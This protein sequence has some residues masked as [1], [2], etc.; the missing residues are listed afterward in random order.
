MFLLQTL[1]SQ[2]YLQEIKIENT[3]PV[4]FEYRWGIRACEELSPR[5]ALEFASEVCFHSYKSE[6]V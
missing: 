4:K 6:V 5:A 1:K 2:R 3:D